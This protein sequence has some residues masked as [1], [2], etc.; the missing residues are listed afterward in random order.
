MSTREGSANV[1]KFKS[2]LLL[3]SFFFLIICVNC[4]CS[5]SDGDSGSLNDDQTSMDMMENDP[6]ILHIPNKQ[7]Y[8]IDIPDTSDLPNEK[9]PGTIFFINW[10]DIQIIAF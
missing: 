8:G 9:K 6:N 1:D 5:A 2:S 4:G 10:L 7:G 3:I